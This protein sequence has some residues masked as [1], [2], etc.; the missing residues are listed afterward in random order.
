MSGHHGP[1]GLPQRADMLGRPIGGCAGKPRPARDRGNV[2][3]KIGQIAAFA[4]AGW[5]EHLRGL[6]PAYERRCGAVGSLNGR[7]RTRASGVRA[8]GSGGGAARD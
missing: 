5:R 1:L 8:P 7:P 6:A 2:T 4:A 3:D